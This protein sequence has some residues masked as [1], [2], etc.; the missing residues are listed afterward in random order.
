MFLETFSCWRGIRLGRVSNLFVARMP[1]LPC[2]DF[3]PLSHVAEIRFTPAIPAVI[4]DEFQR[5]YDDEDEHPLPDESRIKAVPY[6]WLRLVSR[7]PRLKR[8]D[9]SRLRVRD[10]VTFR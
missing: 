1:S 10:D 8:L 7:A 5:D 4:L 9:L 3:C 2:A 6:P